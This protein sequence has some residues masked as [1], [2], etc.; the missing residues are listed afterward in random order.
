MGLINIDDRDVHN[1]Y[2]VMNNQV[3]FKDQLL[4][5]KSN[6][7]TA[8]VVNLGHGRYK[9]NLPVVLCTGSSVIS[10]LNIPFM[11]VFEKVEIKHVN[12]VDIDSSASLDYLIQH[13]H[14]QSYWMTLLSI[15]SSVSSDII[16]EYD[17]FYLE[18][19]DYQII[20]TSLSSD[21]LLIAV[22]VLWTGE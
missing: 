1:Y 16:D 10:R 18:R 7:S 12:S 3:N 9:L 5:L 14:H 17:N 15:E 4:R 11:H 22:Y 13:K 2:G 19:G 6:N 8:I 20:S 21:K